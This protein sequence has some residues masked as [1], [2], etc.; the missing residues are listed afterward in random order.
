[1]TFA[2]RAHQAATT[3]GLPAL[4]TMVAT[5]YTLPDTASLT[6]NTN[7][8]LTYFKEQTSGV[9]TWYGATVAGIGSNYEIRFTLTS[10]TAWDVGLVSGTWY[11]LSS[12]R[13]VALTANTVDLTSTI[14]VA[15]R[16]AATGTVVTTGTLNLGVYDEP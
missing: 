16:E 1:M 7:G 9:S 4:G 10:G 2:A 8:T 6:F 12:A 3:S 13:G 15:I 5:S 11:S 14:A